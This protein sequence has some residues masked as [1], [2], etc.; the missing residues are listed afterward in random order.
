MLSTYRLRKTDNFEVPENRSKKSPSANETENGYS[1][2]ESDVLKNVEFENGKNCLVPEKRDWKRVFDDSEDVTPF[3][4]DFKPLKTGK[5]FLFLC[6]Q[7][8]KFLEI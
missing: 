1:Q 8:L 2:G 3:R 5:V 4:I 6:M 7:Q